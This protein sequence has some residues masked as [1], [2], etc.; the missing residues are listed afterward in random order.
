MLLSG[1]CS[2]PYCPAE[3][4]YRI[5]RECAGI[6]LRA[7]YMLAFSTKSDMIL[8]DLD[9]FSRYP[10]QVA[11]VFSFSCADE[12]LSARLEPFAAPPC[13]VSRR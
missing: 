7:G 11:A 1:L 6:A 4:G 8:R 10:G 13:A 9:L 2:D 3:E 5:T 12:A